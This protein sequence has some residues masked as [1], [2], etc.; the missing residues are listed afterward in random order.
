[1]L[2]VHTRSDTR[3]EHGALNGS[4]TDQEQQHSCRKS[5]TLILCFDG[6]DNEY[7]LENTNIVKFYAL[8][9][10]NDFNEQMAYYQAGVGT[11]YS[12]GVVSPA[13]TWFAKWMDIGFA[14]YL[15]AHVIDGYRF[16]MQNYRVGDRICLF[17]FSRGAYTARA[18]AGFL[19]KL[20]LLP[21]DNQAQI[22]LAYKLYQNTSEASHELARGFKETFC[23]DVSI[24]FL[25]VWDT[26]SSVGMVV[27]RTLP[28]TNSNRSVKVFRHALSLDERRIKFQPNLYHR[29]TR[30]RDF[31][32]EETVFESMGPVLRVNPVKE[33]WFTGCHADVGGGSVQNSVKST[34]A[35]IPLRWMVKEIIEAGIPIQFDEMALERAGLS[36]DV[37]QA[38]AKSKPS[39]LRA[40]EEMISQ[41]DVTDAL[42]PIYDQ[43]SLNKF[44]WAIEMLPMKVMWQDIHNAWHTYW[45][46]NL[47]RG[48]QIHLEHPQ[49][50]IT[51]RERMDDPSLKYKPQAKYTPGTEE[52]VS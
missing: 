49:F 16:L 9:K 14:W 37:L 6:T 33:V 19:H 43:L 13:L 52:Y 29:S 28:F 20:G 44:W 47:G 46:V 22:P 25:G 18:L 17:G 31:G 35:N 30:G 3:S 21:R 39:S 5:K 24:D 11:W 12:P 4:S 27:S 38:Q 50:H 42:Q 1:M 2:P 7:D 41:A 36:Y 51:V 26:V 45:T 10:K 15:D 34:L 32:S 40:T 48:R 23:Q 8:L